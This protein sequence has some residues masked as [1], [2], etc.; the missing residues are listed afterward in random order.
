MFARIRTMP[1]AYCRM[2]APPNVTELAGFPSDAAVSAAMAW[3]VSIP[4]DA[5][6][7]LDLY[8]PVEIQILVSYSDK[9]FISFSR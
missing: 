3:A 7:A 6:P 9:H 4:I 5:N 1:E 2:P 8:I